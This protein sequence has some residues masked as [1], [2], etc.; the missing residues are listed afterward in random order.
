MQAPTIDPTL[1]AAVQTYFLALAHEKTIEPKVR[2]YQRKILAEMQAVINL[3][4]GDRD[5]QLITEPKNAFMMS[6]SDIDIY[7]DRQADEA[8]KAG[9]ELES[10]DHC[11]LGAAKAM[12]DKA[13]RL[14][15]ECAA[16]T[17]APLLGLDTKYIY[18]ETYTKLLDLVLGLVVASFPNLAKETLKLV[19]PSVISRHE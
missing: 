4:F 17:L 7:C 12:R 10:R 6:D 5:G 1:K 11:P 15:I 14:V 3:G 8:I 9:F 19:K 16:N 2:A 13:G 18:G